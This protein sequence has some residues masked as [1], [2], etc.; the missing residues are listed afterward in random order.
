MKSSHVFLN[1]TVIMA[2]QSIISSNEP[3]LPMYKY[4]TP[5]A[6]QTMQNGWNDMKQGACD[7]HVQFDDE[8]DPSQCC[9]KVIT[10]TTHCLYGISQVITGTVIKIWEEHPSYTAISTTVESFSDLYNKKK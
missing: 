3:I 4:Q 2:T 1:I 9:H 6:I 10:G 5:T 7:L 8:V